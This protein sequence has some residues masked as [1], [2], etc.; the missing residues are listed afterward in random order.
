M[1]EYNLGRVVGNGIASIE[2]VST[3]G[4]VKT[5]RIIFTDGD[6]FDYQLTDGSDATV[7]IDATLS[8]SSTNPVQNKVIKSALDDIENLIGD[9]IIYIIGSGN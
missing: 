2:L 7:T 5:Y 6:Y 9:A 8:S 1:V 3:T 4:L